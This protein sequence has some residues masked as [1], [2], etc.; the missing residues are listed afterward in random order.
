MKILFAFI[1][2]I[3]IASNLFSS[4]KDSTKVTGTPLFLI[5]SNFHQGVSKN[6]YIS[7]F[8]IKR[9][10]IGYD[11][12]LDNG[13]N[14]SIKLD[15][16]SPDSSNNYSLIKRT[17][18]FRNVAIGYNYKNLSIAFGI[19]DNQQ[20]KVQEKF[21]AKRYLFKSFIDEYKFLPSTALGIN[22]SYK[23]NKKISLEFGMV[24][25]EYLNKKQG[26][27]KYIYNIGINYS[28][29]DNLIMKAYST[30]TGDVNDIITNGFFCA[31]KIIPELKIAAEYNTKFE[32]IDNTTLN[33]YGYSIFSEYKINK[34]FNIFARYDL[35]DS[36]N[37]NNS[38]S[39]WNIDKNG[40]AI[41]GG[42]EYI[43]NKNLRLS[44][45]YQDWHPAKTNSNNKAYIF[46][47]LEFGIFDSYKRI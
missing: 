40:F 22:A 33:L 21:W 23:F 25:G 7:N 47:N 42:V 34:K 43:I 35:L 45:N 17:A 15:I 44:L 26:L 16:G 28:P 32:F 24:N 18:Y 12:N 27:D 9:A 46:L 2:L 3:T 13:F 6:N 14:A 38:T 37:I 39:S 20:H 5:Y 31:Y 36:N 41:I 11:F 10:Y 30:Y 8:D 29:I 1:F 19:I 4:E